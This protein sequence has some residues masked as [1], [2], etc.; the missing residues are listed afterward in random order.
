MAFAEASAVR[1][2]LRVVERACVRVLRARELAVRRWR[3]AA[4]RFALAL[5]CVLVRLRC[6]V[7]RP[8][9]ERLLVLVFSG[10]VWNSPLR[11]A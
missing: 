1:P 11:V 6:D 10:I 9:V 5:R 4:A 3:V 8:D 2:A 7:E